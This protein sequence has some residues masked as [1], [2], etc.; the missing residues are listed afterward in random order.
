MTVKALGVIK[1]AAIEASELFDVICF[2]TV[3]PPTKFKV[4]ELINVC[5]C[6]QILQMRIDGAMIVEGRSAMTLCIT[7]L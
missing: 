1:I 3:T 5:R 7:N 6:S 4:N 2:P